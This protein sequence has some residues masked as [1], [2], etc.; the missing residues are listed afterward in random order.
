MQRPRPSVEKVGASRSTHFGIGIL[1]AELSTEQ[2]LDSPA[3]A[4]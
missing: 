2:T 4:I 1:T 3:T